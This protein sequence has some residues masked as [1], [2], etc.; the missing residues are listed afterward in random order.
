MGV[1]NANGQD[2]ALST[3]GGITEDGF[4]LLSS[5]NY[6]LRNDNF[7]QASVFV[8]FAKD[9]YKENLK[10]P[11]NDF[12]VNAGYFQNVYSTKNKLLK[13]SLGLGGIFGYESVNRG[14]RELA[15]GALVM[16]KS[17]FIYGAFIGF[18][19]DIY[20]ND[21]VSVV[22]KANEFYHHNSNLGQFTGYCGLGIRYFFN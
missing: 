17:G 10:I 14:D 8:S 11:Y 4:G 15:N 9:H 21:K 16:S 20:L 13:I 19:T 2:S 22:V 5:Y 18:D 3:T 6:Y 1:V 7:I 12:T